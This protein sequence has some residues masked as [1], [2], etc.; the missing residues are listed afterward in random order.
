M[1][2]KLRKQFV[3]INMA[4]VSIVV[5]AVLSGIG[6]M[7]YQR[8]I[9]IV[10]DAMEDAVIAAAQSQGQG[11]GQWQGQGFGRDANK[12]PFGDGADS[13]FP[14]PT[15]G[16]DDAPDDDTIQNAPQIGGGNDNVTPVAVYRATS[17]GNFQMVS[18]ASSAAL[19]D[20]VLEKAASELANTSNGEGT[21]HDL[22]L[23]Y[24]KTTRGNTT[25]YAF[26]S[27]SSA[28]DWRGLFLMLIL[29]G[30]G[31]LLVFFL[32]SLV[33]SRW[34]LKPVEES[35]TKQK[36]FLADASHELKTP[37][38][39]ILAN[40]DIMLK[41]PERS[42]ASQEQWLESTQHEARGMQEM[43]VSM[44][45]L[46]R[47][48]AEA[49]TGE[50]GGGAAAFEDVNLSDVALGSLLQFESRAF[51]KQV[52]FEDN[53][54]DDLHILGNPN[55]IER[56]C[57]TLFDNA[58]KYAPAGSTVNA[59]LKVADAAAYRNLPSTTVHGEIPKGPVAVLSVSN[60][61]DPIAAEDLPHIFDRFYRTDKARTHD[62]G[63]N[64]YG[65]GLAIA[66][67]TVTAHKGCIMA[68]SEANAG[69]TFT[70]VLPLTRR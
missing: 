31:T 32:L 2:K 17:I 33:L 58:C 47:L 14:F 69:T 59:R 30:V 4:M 9:S 18:R 36:Q 63:N 38:T 51:E 26:A 39:V 46:A 68:T 48:D 16:E 66:A 54:E 61:G 24:L 27:T 41:H 62:A 8:S 55:Q 52:M 29:T 12:L 37:I 43:V 25:Y 7:S 3:L 11:Q 5:I 44:L 15:L 34:A 49:D 21:L 19:S 45:D 40:T 65:L 60:Q 22:G 28:T 56:L 67:G 50:I 1:L 20:E 35:W 13:I 70:V 57:G 10:F 53:V 23:F 6:A 42:V 64:S